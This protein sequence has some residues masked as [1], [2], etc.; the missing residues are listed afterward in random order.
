MVDFA[1]LASEK[2][3]EVER[4]NP[5]NDGPRSPGLMAWQNAGTHYF[6]WVFTPAMLPGDDGTPAQ[7]SHTFN[8]YSFFESNKFNTPYEK[9][10]KEVPTILAVGILGADAVATSV[11]SIQ[12]NTTY[13]AA[14]KAEYV[15]DRTNRIEQTWLTGTQLVAF[16][17]KTSAYE[18]ML[19]LVEAGYQPATLD[20]ENNI[21]YGTWFKAHLPAGTKAYVVTPMPPAWK[22]ESVGIVTTKR[23]LPLVDDD[24][25]DVNIEQLCTP[26]SEAKRL[27]WE[28]AAPDKTQPF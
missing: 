3:K 28:D 21:T 27:A 22:P 13:D 25:N 14:K 5:T 1:A 24:G 11:A 19:R 4:D 20:A 16:G 10:L 12:K 23:V 26:Y 15:A 2:L 6:Q 9:R 17:M 7:E 18:A 8:Q